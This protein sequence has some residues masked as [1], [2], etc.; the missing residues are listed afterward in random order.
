MSLHGDLACDGSSRVCP[1]K[2]LFAVKEVQL[3]DAQRLN[4]TKP[5]QTKNHKKPETLHPS[6]TSAGPRDYWLEWPQPTAET[7]LVNWLHSFVF[8]TFLYLR[9]T[10]SAPRN[11]IN[12]YPQFL[13]WSIKTLHPHTTWLSFFY[14]ESRTVFAI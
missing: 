2:S 6:S 3:T 1:Q 8:V 7:I 5:N 10:I 4:G 9:V 11:R 14:W 12:E 13:P